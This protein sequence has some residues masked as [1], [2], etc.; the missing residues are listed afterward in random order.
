MLH[1]DFLLMQTLLTVTVTAN[2]SMFGNWQSKRLSRDDMMK[3]LVDCKGGE[4]LSI[5]A[6]E[7]NHVQ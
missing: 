4:M 5:F 1:Q 7:C 6:E 2:P 3:R